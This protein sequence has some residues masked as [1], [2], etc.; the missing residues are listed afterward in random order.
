MPFSEGIVSD[1]VWRN[2]GMGPSE[3]EVP[4]AGG[5]TLASCIRDLSIM[6]AL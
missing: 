6:R 5:G 3:A 4:K 2:V 1:G